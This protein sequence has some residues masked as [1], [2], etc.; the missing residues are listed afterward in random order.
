MISI[1]RRQVVVVVL[2]L[3]LVDRRRISL[4]CRGRDGLLADRLDVD[5]LA[6]RAALIDEPLRGLADV[7]VEARRR[8]PCRPR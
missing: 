2:F 5:V 1:V 4:A 3:L 7:R 8:S 6:L